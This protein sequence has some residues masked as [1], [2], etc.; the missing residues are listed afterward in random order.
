M[1]LAYADYQDLYRSSITLVNKYIKVNPISS[2]KSCSE[3]P[4]YQ[5]RSLPQW[6]QSLCWGHWGQREEGSLDTPPGGLSCRDQCSGT[7]SPHR[8]GCSPAHR[9]LP[10]TPAHHLHHTKI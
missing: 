9:C 5:P 4:T 6:S 2:I 7:L 3:K 8:R 1:I 10:H